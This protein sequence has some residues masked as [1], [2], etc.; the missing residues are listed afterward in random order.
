MQ[1]LAHVESFEGLIEWT[2]RVSVPRGGVYL[3]SSSVLSK[4]RTA[5]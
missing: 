5:I 3:P 4:A 1:L 2:I